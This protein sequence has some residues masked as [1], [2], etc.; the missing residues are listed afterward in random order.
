[1]MRIGA[2]C[3]PG[4]G[5][6]KRVA[7]CARAA[8]VAAALTQVADIATA[9]KMIHN[10][11]AVRPRIGQRG[12]TVDVTIRGVSLDDAREV[13]LYRPGI[14]VVT[15]GKTTTLAKPEGRWH[16]G[17]IDQEV[18]CTF[19]IAP[20]CPLGMH[21]FRLRTAHEL[22]SLGTFHV[23]PFPIIDENE[24]AQHSNDTPATAVAVAPNV[25]VRGRLGG[26]GIDDVDFYRVPVQAG[27]RLSVEVDSVRISDHA[28][29]DSE[30]DLAVRVLDGAGRELAGNDENPL[31]QQDPLVSLKIADDGEAFVEVRRS[32]FAS[33]D[34]LY[35]VHI[36]TNFR[37]LAIY[38]AGGPV[39]KTI[40][41]RLLG[42][43]LGEISETVVVPGKSGTFEYFGDAPSPLL[44]RASPFGN[45]LE[46]PDAAETLVGSLP[47]ALNGI[48]DRPGDVDAFRLTAKKGDRCRVRVYAATLGSPID[49]LIRI[50]RVD[51]AGKPDDVEVEA[52][53][54]SYNLSNRDIYGMSFRSGGGLP[55]VLDPSVIW[56]PKADGD[57][58][59]EVGDAGGFGSPSGV[60]RVEIEPAYD[61]IHTVL[62]CWTIDW[63]E[64]MRVSGLAVPQGNRWT[65]NFVTAPF[66]G[67]TYGGDL[68]VVGHGLPTG[69]RVVS[70]PIPKAYHGT[71]W[72]VQFVADPGVKPGG[73][74]FTLEVQ[75][76]DPSKKIESGSHQAVPFNNHPGGDAWHPVRTDRYAMAVTDPAPISIDIVPPTVPL[77]RGGELTIPVKITRRPGFDEPVEFQ[78]DFAPKGVGLPPMATI[79]P[80]ETEATLRISA[81]PDPK[82]TPL[83]TGPLV[84]MAT[85]TNEKIE[86][87]LGVGRIRVSSEIV[88]LT[89]AEPFVELASE[90][91]GV[92]RG[93]RTKYR[94]TV[95]PK[96]PFEGQA[97]VRLLGLPKGVSAVGTSPTITKDSTE[98]VFEIEATDEALMGLVQNIACELTVMMGGQEVRQRS[99]N[100]R[101]RVD[102]RL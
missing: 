31:H 42:D 88:M 63:A 1:M 62:A 84:V 10:I 16:G 97:A 80:G 100:G 8:L 38:P 76:V 33:A 13:I 22:T 54:A 3:L 87:Y 11:E 12:T 52:D 2:S 67:N 30:F 61:A 41:A 28:Y 45:V 32:L 93:G 29:G 34:T 73:A 71:Q 78:C 20:G 47:A 66:Q 79:A 68:Q 95:T 75:P 15:I 102:P 70:P 44:L 27:Q 83:G 57:Y 51:A 21:P 48:L 25:T 101:L 39:G 46:E 77:V 92:R 37:P 50:R 58:V 69:V 24:H 23:G 99:G 81:D 60:Y 59:L 82:K 53:D 90:P 35:C 74:V 4:C 49:P 55:D 17:Y 9:G 94:W 85:T 43:P 14:R 18:V 5:R 6:L 91:E 40:S 86:G 26:G 89:V 64:S 72:P 65:V 19:E 7:V 96:T 36:G 56:E 98:V